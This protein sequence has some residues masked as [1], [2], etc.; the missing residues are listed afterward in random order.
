M[1]KFNRWEP[2]SSGRF[3]FLGFDFHWQKS[4]RNPNYRVVKRS[5]NGITIPDT[6]IALTL[7]YIHPLQNQTSFQEN[8]LTVEEDNHVSTRDRF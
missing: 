2:E 4:R 5:T 6:L 1:V 7:N 8:F 3:T